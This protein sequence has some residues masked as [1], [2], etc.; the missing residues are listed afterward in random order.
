MTSGLRPGSVISNR[1]AARVWL[2]TASAASPSHGRAVLSS[3][4]RVTATAP[5]QHW[6][7]SGPSTQRRVERRQLP[8]SESI[9]C[10]ASEIIRS[11]S[12][13]PSVPR[14]AVLLISIQVPV[15]RGVEPRT[16]FSIV[17]T[18]HCWSLS[19]LWARRIQS[20]GP[21]APGPFDP[22]GITGW[23]PLQRRLRQPGR[24]RVSPVHPTE[25]TRPRG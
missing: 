8:W 12:P 4:S 15:P 19:R 14:L 22:A 23:S 3:G 1:T 7:R 6:F 11:S 21:G 13:P 2:P 24:I 20:T 25:A 18:A 10:A 16:S 5:P 17:S 9:A